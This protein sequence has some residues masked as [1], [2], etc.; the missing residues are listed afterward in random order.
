LNFALLCRLDDRV[1]ALKW[2]HGRKA[3]S[4]SV[5]MLVA[6]FD[7]DAGTL[8]RPETGDPEIRCEKDRRSTE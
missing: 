1:I 6:R 5:N 4:K 8:Q 7:P 3:V 2:D